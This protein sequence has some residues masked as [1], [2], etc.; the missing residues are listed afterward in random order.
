MKGFH[1]KGIIMSNEIEL[2]LA[3][4]LEREDIG[5]GF[6]KISKKVMDKLNCSEGDILEINGFNK[7]AAIAREKENEE[8]QGV[9]RLDKFKRGKNLVGD[10][11]TVKKVRPTKVENIEVIPSFKIDREIAVRLLLEQPVT[12]EDEHIT[13]RFKGRFKKHPEQSEK[14]EI[15]EIL[16]KRGFIFIPFRIKKIKPRETCILSRKGNIDVINPYM[17]EKA[18]T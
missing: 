11:I 16:E 18:L 10:R 15:S 9:I 12:E 17:K 3:P 4:I 2:T 6:A 5:R 13:T 8:K 7:T 1:L 14:V